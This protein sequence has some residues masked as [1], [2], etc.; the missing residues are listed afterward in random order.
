[1]K[2]LLFTILLLGIVFLHK[3]QL[4]FA[5]YDPDTGINYEISYRTDV[6]GTASLLYEQEQNEIRLKSYWNTFDVDINDSSMTSEIQKYID[7]VITQVQNYP[8]KNSTIGPSVIN[9]H[10]FHT[11]EEYFFRWLELP[12][13]YNATSIIVKQ[14]IPLIVTGDGNGNLSISNECDMND[15]KIATFT[16]PPIWDYSVDEKIT[17]QSYQVSYTI[18]N[19]YTPH[20]PSG[21][22]D[23]YTGKTLDEVLRHCA[24]N[25]D[26]EK[27]IK[28][29]VYQHY[30]ISIL[31]NSSYQLNI[32]LHYGNT[33]DSVHSS[34][35]SIPKGDT[36]AGVT[37][38]KTDTATQTSDMASGTATSTPDKTDIQQVETNDANNKK[39]DNQSS[40][41]QVVQNK[42]DTKNKQ[43]ENTKNNTTWLI[44]IILTIIISVI[45]II[46]LAYKRNFIFKGID[47][48]EK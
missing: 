34:V 27:T 1:M 29:S 30:S 25:A 44:I 36:V 43:N 39:T 8:P 24:Q 11:N 3:G 48:K 26:L 35:E 6:T 7:E 21:T 28:V 20:F 40:H 12:Q 38:K 32:E 41:Q 16:L 45:A 13:N 42:T 37:S 10:T 15:T 4:A 18:A 19:S 2:R 9:G 14:N 22:R 31:A 33:P 46:Y 47:S 5:A 17:S 23:F